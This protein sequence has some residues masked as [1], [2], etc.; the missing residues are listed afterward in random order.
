MSISLVCICSQSIDMSYR[1][2]GKW[3]KGRKGRA[4]SFE[5][6]QRYQKITLAL[7][8]TSRLMQEIDQTRLL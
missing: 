4:L 7:M 5:N 2:A 3:L 8:E 6:I 1:T